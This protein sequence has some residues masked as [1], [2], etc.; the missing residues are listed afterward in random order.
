MGS[1]EEPEE[2]AAE[3]MKYPYEKQNIKHAGLWSEDEQPEQV[4]EKTM[5]YEP[6]NLKHDGLWSEG[7]EPRVRFQEEPE[8]V[9]LVA[10]ENEVDYNVYEKKNLNKDG[11]S[12]AEPEPAVELMEQE[13]M[14]YVEEEEP[15]NNNFWY[16]LGGAG[17]GLTTSWL[18]GGKNTK[19]TVRYVPQVK[20]AQQQRASQIK[21]AQAQ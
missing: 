9:A 11:M 7:E 4:D 6:K 21:Y 20:Y 12:D 16:F 2:H 14:V 15:E 1:E 8:P 13:S 19:E 10:R 5:K 17:V 18:L 3:T